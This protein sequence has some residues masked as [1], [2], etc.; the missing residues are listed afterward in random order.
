MVRGY[1]NCSPLISRLP[2]ATSQAAAV[3]AWSLILRPLLMRVTSL[4]G[5]LCR[6]FHLC[7]SGVRVFLIP[8]FDLSPTECSSLY[9]QHLG[10]AALCDLMRT[11]ASVC[12]SSSPVRL[13]QV[14]TGQI[15]CQSGVKC[16]MIVDVEDCLLLVLIKYLAMAEQHI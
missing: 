2:L 13:D 12:N 3:A 9:F 11:S 10:N 4:F 8:G 7:R 15:S 16:L 6:F 1:M 5:G 14:S